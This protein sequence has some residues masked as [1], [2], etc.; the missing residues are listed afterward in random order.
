MPQGSVVCPLLFSIY[1]ND[2]AENILSNAKQSAN[3]TNL[4]S[5]VHNINHTS[6]DL[7]YDLSIIK[8]WTFLWKTK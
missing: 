1:E 6:A 4:Y 2:L 8:Y 3:D 5:V 7:T